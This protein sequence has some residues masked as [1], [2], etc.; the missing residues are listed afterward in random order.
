MNAMIT[1]LENS[2]QYTLSVAEAMPEKEYH[3]QI[4]EGAFDFRELMNH[5]AYGIEWWKDNFITGTKTAWEPPAVRKGK[6]EI[7][8]SLDVAY[9]GL[10]R[11]I[12]KKGEEAASGF[13]ATLDH[14]THHRGQ[15]VLHLRSRGIQPPE[16]TY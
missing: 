10:R 8:G 16:Y 12:E 14:I 4:V 5:I 3:S 1:I 7:V 9:D 6:K 13:H 15:A 11:A 2:R